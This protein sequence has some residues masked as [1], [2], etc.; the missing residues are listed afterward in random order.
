MSAEEI[1]IGRFATWRG[2]KCIIIDAKYGRSGSTP[3]VQI[4][5]AG[6]HTH[7]TDAAS[8]TPYREDRHDHERSN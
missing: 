8:L 3:W 4:R 7:W 5:L 2:L 6:N 1:T